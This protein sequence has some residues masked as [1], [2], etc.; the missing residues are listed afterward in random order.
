MLGS[1]FEVGK[2]RSRREVPG[3]AEEEDSFLQV[4]PLLKSADARVI[5]SHH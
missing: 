1:E 5:S 2:R 4:G 3:G